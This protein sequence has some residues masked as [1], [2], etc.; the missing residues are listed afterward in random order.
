MILF[1][2][3]NFL[4]I[5][6]VTKSC[7]RYHLHGR[8]LTHVKAIST[9]IYPYGRDS[10]YGERKEIALKVLEQLHVENDTRPKLVEIALS[11]VPRL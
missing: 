6:Q 11:F 5:I 2:A 8:D 10:E 1:L 4:E 7:E 9:E 3:L